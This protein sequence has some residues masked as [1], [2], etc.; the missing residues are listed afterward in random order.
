MDPA[1][2]SFFFSLFVTSPIITFRLGWY[3]QTS[4]G[5]KSADNEIYRLSR[6]K[7]DIYKQLQSVTIEIQGVQDALNGAMRRLYETS[8]FKQALG[9]ILN[10]RNAPTRQVTL[11]VAQEV[12]ECLFAV[13]NHCVEGEHRIK[14]L[15]DS[16]EELNLKL[17]QVNPKLNE[18]EQTN[19]VLVNADSER[20]LVIVENQH[21]KDQLENAKL[22]LKKSIEWKRRYEAELDEANRQINK[23]A[24]DSKKH[25]SELEA[26]ESELAEALE[27]LALVKED[28][29]E[30]EQDLAKVKAEMNDVMKALDGVGD[31]KGG[32]RGGRGGNANNDE[33]LAAEKLERELLATLTENERLRMKLSSLEFAPNSNGNGMD[34]LKY[35]THASSNV[36]GG[37][38][39]GL[40]P[41]VSVNKRHVGGLSGSS[42]S[43]FTYDHPMHGSYTSRFADGGEGNRNSTYKF[44]ATSGN[45][46]PGSEVILEGGSISVHQSR[47]GSLDVNVSP[48]SGKYEVLIND[49]SNEMNEG[50]SKV[51]L[52]DRLSRIQSTFASLRR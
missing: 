20:K 23:V 21:L 17:A 48:T 26:R 52:E 51:R 27:E 44:P 34:N 14:V 47:R 7:E 41:A 37:P 5:L 42:T 35:L 38:P 40:S 22:E 32:G 3:L 1:S 16:K 29:K 43:S 25:I 11:Q 13:V 9:Y 45:K 50:S 24:G 30:R 12:I 36:F 33:D 19:K 4:D 31:N 18:Y 2:S 15:E 10:E 6:E 46:G 28:L 49:N 8:R 39:P